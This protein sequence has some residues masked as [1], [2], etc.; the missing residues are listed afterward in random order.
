MSVRNACKNV[1]NIDRQLIYLLFFVISKLSRD[2]QGCVFNR[3]GL[4]GF[5]FAASAIICAIFAAKFYLSRNSNRNKSPAESRDMN[6]DCVFLDFYDN[7]DLWHFFSAATIFLIF[8]GLLIL[9]DD[10]LDVPR[11]QILVY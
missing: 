10:L 11:D 7:H 9:D 3:H 8:L 2:R 5:I 4:A 6:G 1:Y